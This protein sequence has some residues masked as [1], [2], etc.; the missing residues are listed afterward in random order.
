MLSQRKY[1]KRKIQQMLL[2]SVFNHSN[3]QIVLSL[4][5]GGLILFTC[6]KL[7]ILI[8]GS[9]FDELIQLSEYPF[10]IWRCQLLA[11]GGISIQRTPIPSKQD[12]EKNISISH[13]TAYLDE[14]HSS[15][16]N[17]IQIC[18]SSNK[19]YLV[20]HFCTNLG[21]LDFFTFKDFLTSFSIDL[22]DYE[23]FE[24]QFLF[25]LF[26]DYGKE[27]SI[28]KI[29]EDTGDVFTSSYAIIN[30]RM[31]SKQLQRN[32]ISK[33]ADQKDETDRE[34]K[35]RI[36]EEKKIV[37]QEIYEKKYKQKTLSDY[38]NMED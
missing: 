30:R 10:D 29:L 28:L 33:M 18:L 6:L 14:I 1:Q 24:K 23:E 25:K 38:M 5:F 7:S 31:K 19:Y 4:F 12:M 17:T 9:S 22:K 26:V 2:I 8:L 16:G 20:V 36:D 21:G 3:P 27:C 34:I 37:I 13:L 11:S 15:A 35:K 32:I